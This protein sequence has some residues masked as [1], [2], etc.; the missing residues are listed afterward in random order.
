MTGWFGD[1]SRTRWVTAAV[2]DLL[3]DHGDG[4]KR[5]HNESYGRRGVRLWQL[6]GASEETDG[7]AM[8]ARDER[9]GTGS[10]RDGAGAARSWRQLKAMEA[11]PAT[12]ARALRRQ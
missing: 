3:Q 11:Q 4:A 8:E 5:D 1:G 9:R 12:T 2:G 10:S 6:E 7:G